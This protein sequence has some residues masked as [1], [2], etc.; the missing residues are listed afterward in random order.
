MKTFANRILLN[1]FNGEAVCRIDKRFAKEKN[2]ANQV[3]SRWSAEK[4]YELTV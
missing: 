3:Q 4:Y 2:K 1:N